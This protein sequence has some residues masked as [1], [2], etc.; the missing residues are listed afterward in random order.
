MTAE[1]VAERESAFGGI[2]D[3]ANT[4]MQEP[5]GAGLDVPA[6]LM[7]LEDTVQ[8]V[9]NE[10]ITPIYQTVEAR[11]LP[12]QQLSTEQIEETIRTWHEQDD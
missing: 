2:A 3:Q 12:P 10:Q 6:W 7:A 1:D 11:M 4:F 5:S 9:K 8:A